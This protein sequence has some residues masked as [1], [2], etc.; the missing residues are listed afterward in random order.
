MSFANRG[1]ESYMKVY[2]FMSEAELKMYFNEECTEIGRCYSSQIGLNSFQYKKGVR[3]LHFFK[4]LKDIEYIKKDMCENLE[5]SETKKRFFIGC[6]NIPK[7]LLEKGKCKGF[8]ADQLSSGYDDCKAK[9]VP[10]YA[11]E[12]SKMKEDFLI[13]FKQEKLDNQL[14]WQKD[15]MKKEIK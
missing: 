14:Y 11:I 1:K 9:F 3:Y 12:S 13:Y 4:N 8:Y 2:R 6:F 7:T 15:E 10:E 5:K